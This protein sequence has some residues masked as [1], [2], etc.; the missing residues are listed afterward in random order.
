MIFSFKWCVC[1]CVRV[2]CVRACVRAVCCVCVVCGVC[3]C[4]RGRPCQPAVAVGA[5]YSSMAICA[6]VSC[7][8]RITLY[9]FI[10]NVNPLCRPL[11]MY[12]LMYVG[13][14]C[15]HVCVDAVY[16]LMPFPLSVFA[17]HFCLH[18]SCIFLRLSF[19]STCSSC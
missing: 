13:P 17:T 1:V 15:I 8:I 19:Q 16:P 4:M 18:M 3:A 6:G 12:L 9:V 14:I 5:M 10:Y 11:C 7:A 2:W